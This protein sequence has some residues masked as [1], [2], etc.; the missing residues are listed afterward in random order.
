MV[1]DDGVEYTT[2]T[3]LKFAVT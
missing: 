1:S 2:V 3:C